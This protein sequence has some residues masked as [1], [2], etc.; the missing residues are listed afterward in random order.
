MKPVM[1]RCDVETLVLLAD[2][3]DDDKAVPCPNCGLIN[4]FVNLEYESGAFLVFEV[5]CLECGH[6]EE[7]YEQQG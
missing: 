4:F 3:E 1:G 2:A 6:T 7:R 5:E